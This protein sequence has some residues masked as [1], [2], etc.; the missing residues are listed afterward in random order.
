MSI[1]LISV[2]ALII[3]IIAVL[4]CI[5]Y[6][7]DNEHSFAIKE[8]ELKYKFE[9]ERAQLHRKLTEEIYAQELS[10]IKEQ[11]AF[12]YEEYRQQQLEKINLEIELAENRLKEDLDSYANDISTEWNI[13]S[14]IKN[15]TFQEKEEITK[16]LNTL[17]AQ[18]DQLIAA[19]KR[20]EELKN[21]QTFH[22][23]FLSLDDVNDIKYLEELKPQLRRPALLAKLI[24]TEYFQ[25]PVKEMLNRVVGNGCKRCGIYK[26]TYVAD[27]R[28]Y[29]GQSVDIS[30]R[31]TNHIK[32]ALGIE[33]GAAHARFHDYLAQLGIQNFTFEVLEDCSKEKLN[34]REK[35]YIDFY[36]TNDYGWNS[37]KGNI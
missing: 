16:E 5:G 31:W 34:E 1:F 37:T 8:K 18:R 2:I 14:K 28:A 11:A 17:K 9:Q 36:K 22:S 3:I 20:E 33:G 6:K 12:G 7:K 26:I 15:N 23:I 29:I 24:W 27:S 30:T 32:T 35:Y 10:Q 4:V 25:R 13:L 21:N 19:L